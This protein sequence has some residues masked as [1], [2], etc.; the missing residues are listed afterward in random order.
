MGLDLTTSDKWHEQQQHGKEHGTR[1]YSPQ[2]NQDLDKFVSLQWLVSPSLGKRD[3]VIE[4]FSCTAKNER[5][6]FPELKK[7]SPMTFTIAK[8]RCLLLS[9][10]YPTTFGAVILQK[11][12]NG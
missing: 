1:F 8:F 2:S 4:D 9:L 11:R 12:I 7:K 6:S 5:P 3:P 10:R